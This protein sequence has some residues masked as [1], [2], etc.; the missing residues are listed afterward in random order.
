[1]DAETFMSPDHSSKA[2]HLDQ[3][4]SMIERMGASGREGDTPEG[5]TIRAAFVQMYFGALAHND[6]PELINEI[7]DF[8]E[9]YNALAQELYD[10]VKGSD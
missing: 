4:A 9:P 7:A 5:T 6:S 8:I 10:V 3:T 1:M 2:E